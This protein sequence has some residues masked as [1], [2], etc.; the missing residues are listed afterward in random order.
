MKRFLSIILALA[1][2]IAMIPATFAAEGEAVEPNLVYSFSKTAIAEDYK[3]TVG[4]DPIKVTS[5]DM[6]DTTKSSGQWF[7]RSAF[8]IRTT[9]ALY[10]DQMTTSVNISSLSSNAII[11][12]IKVDKAGVYVPGAD[13]LSSTSTGLID[14]YLVHTDD[15]GDTVNVTTVNAAIATASYDADATV[16]HAISVDTNAASENPKNE[17]APK[18]SLKQGDYYLFIVTSSGAKASTHASGYEYAQIKYLSL[19]RQPQVAL[20]I[21]SSEIEAGSSTKLTAIAENADATAANVEISYSISPADVV[22][23]DAGGNVT[24]IK[25][26]TATITAKATIGG[27]EYSDSVEIKVNPTT[28]YYEFTS[29]ALGYDTNVGFGAATTTHKGEYSTLEGAY[30]ASNKWMFGAMRSSYAGGIYPSTSHCLYFSV[31]ESEI[32]DSNSGMSLKINIPEGETKTY[33]PQIEYVDSLTYGMTADFYIAECAESGY[34]SDSYL[35]ATDGN[36]KKTSIDTVSGDLKANGADKKIATITA[37]PNSADTYNNIELAP[38]DYWLI[39]VPTGGSRAPSSGKYHFKVKSLTLTETTE[40][41]QNGAYVDAFNVT[42]ETYASAP[43]TSATVNTFTAN[44]GE[45]KDTS[46]A[47]VTSA[48]ATLGN[49]FTVTANEIEGYKFLYWAKGMSTAR[50]QIVSYS[51]EYTFVPT[52][53]N[54]YLIAVY[55]PI[56]ASDEA[57]K[58]EFYNGNGQLIATLVEDGNSP[59]LPEM[60][61]YGVATGWKLYGTEEIIAGGTTV[62]V[63][64][65]KIYVAQ[66]DDLSE[67]YTVTVTGGTGSGSY[68]YGE[69]VTCTPSGEGTFIGWKKD[70]K[71]VSAASTYSFRAW[72][73]CS[74]EALYG[75]STPVFSGK[76][77]KIIIDALTA[78]AKNAVMAEFIGMDDA[79]EKGISFG[80]KRIAMSTNKNQFTV[81]NDESV[82]EVYGYA[83]FKDGTIVYDR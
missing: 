52:V 31:S 59:D 33:K 10:D 16:M 15:F 81:V 62:T 35:L 79:V 56:E 13:F 64:G 25:A 3:D 60:A 54:T 69:V 11:L 48:T 78:G 37:Y 32:R 42:K 1:L 73:S 20:S 40:P 66:Y 7:W 82:G 12:Q 27:V 65:T 63:S 49:Q 39:I 61:G 74:V 30:E 75:D 53:E 83:I 77:M 46:S 24:G 34:Y 4:V 9:K 38:G 36:G 67:S 41:R 5:Y 55:E 18:L 19:T 58:A 43:L 51:E 23:I 6:I 21:E 8:G 14:M 68:K 2:V 47:E 76:K 28:H 50:K 57:A 22:S 71:L 44:L 72:E 70:G 45:T 26:G 17:K 80:T 29:T